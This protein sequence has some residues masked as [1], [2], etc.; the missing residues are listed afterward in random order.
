MSHGSAESTA[1]PVSAERWTLIAVS[2][3]AYIL[4]VA[5]H[6]HGG[7]FVACVLLGGRPL[8]MGAFYVTCDHTR[9][10]TLDSRLVAL[11]G[12]T[13]SLILG[14]ACFAV[15]GK[16]RGAATTYFLWLLGT[17]GLMEAT[18]YLLFS[19]VTGLGDLGTGPDGA[20][21]GV[22]PEL[23]WRAAL[24]LSGALTYVGVVNFCLSRLEPYFLG[25]GPERLALPR[26]AVLTSYFVG[27]ATYLIIGA[28]N[29]HGWQ[30]L[31]TSVLP[32]CL[33]GTSGLLW[34]FQLADPEGRAYGPGFTFE[35]RW[36]WIAAG[37][38]V[39]LGYG[40]IFARTYHW[41]SG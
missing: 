20:L 10:S 30:I 14:L 16:L 9:L 12:P 5:L 39:T 24:T 36:H 29:P 26:R 34:M 8:E 17:V 2:C 3:L 13:V 40:L 18:G 41:S 25:N 27:A 38:L 32:S 11:A 21:S 4:A 28:F 31:L 19:G 35:R 1:Q 7:H 22:S 33:G 15:L 37:L 23:L 6:E